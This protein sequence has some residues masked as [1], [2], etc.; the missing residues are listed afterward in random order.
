MNQWLIVADYE[1]SRSDNV[2]AQVQI[3]STIMNRIHLHT[4]DLQHTQYRQLIC[5]ASESW[6]LAST[7]LSLH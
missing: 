5:L 6:A 2:A 1:E 3:Y 4:Y 7:V